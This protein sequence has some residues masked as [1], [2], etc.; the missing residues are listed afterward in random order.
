MAAMADG[1]SMTPTSSVLGRLPVSIEATTAAG[2]SSEC[3]P[4]KAEGT[5]TTGRA[6]GAVFAIECRVCPVFVNLSDYFLA[7]NRVVSFFWKPIVPAT[8]FGLPQ[9]QCQSPSSWWCAFWLPS[10]WLA[11]ERFGICD[12]SLLHELRPVSLLHRLPLS[13]LY[14]VGVGR[15]SYDL[16]DWITPCYE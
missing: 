11:G 5:C 6:D 12:I 2:D 10:S 16:Q 8:S 4:T 3:G 13:L 1:T 7:D 14:L 9:Q 15:S